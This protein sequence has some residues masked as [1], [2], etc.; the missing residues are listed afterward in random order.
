[1]N[2][3]LRREKQRKGTDKKQSDTDTAIQFDFHLR[4]DD[5]EKLAHEMV[6]QG[7]ISEDEVRITTKHIKSAVAE[8]LMSS[9][10]RIVSVMITYWV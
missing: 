8:V 3:Q 6:A 4:N 10:G 9:V 7:Y 2:L 5:A 1:M